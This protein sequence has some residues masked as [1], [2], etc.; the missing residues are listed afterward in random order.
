VGTDEQH[1]CRRKKVGV[2]FSLLSLTGR[3][4]AKPTFTLSQKHEVA[5]SIADS[6]QR[7]LVKN[8][9]GVKHPDLSVTID[10]D[11]PVFNS[12]FL[13][14]VDVAAKNLPVLA[15]ENDFP[16]ALFPRGELQRWD[17]VFARCVGWRRGAGGFFLLRVFSSQ[18]LPLQYRLR[19]ALALPRR[20]QDQRQEVG[21]QA[22]HV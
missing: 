9:Q 4:Y 8:V 12:I 7:E 11:L 2:F 14:T 22:P 15:F 3:F 16:L 18:L 21:H 17:R 20:V 10:V 1:S 13:G 19:H 6:I 5:F